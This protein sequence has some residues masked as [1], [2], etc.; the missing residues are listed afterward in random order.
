MDVFP[1]T[2][3]AHSFGVC[4]EGVFAFLAILFCG[5]ART[6]GPPLLRF[7]YGFLAERVIAFFCG[8][9]AVS[10]T[11]VE[12]FLAAPWFGSAV[13]AYLYCGFIRCGF[14]VWF[15]AWGTVAVT[16]GGCRAFAGLTGAPEL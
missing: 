5:F 3:G 8:V 11:G 9:R 12:A 6:L 14:L 2:V 10:Q 15:S 13:F 4:V 1:F 7:G 16:L